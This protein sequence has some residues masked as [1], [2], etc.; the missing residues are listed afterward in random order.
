MKDKHN[1]QFVTDSLDGK[2]ELASLVLSSRLTRQCSKRK[3]VRKRDYRIG[4]D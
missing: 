4:I 3:D 1:A 2:L